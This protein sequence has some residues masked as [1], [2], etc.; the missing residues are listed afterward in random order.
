VFHVDTALSVYDPVHTPYN[1]DTAAALRER[2]QS[3]LNA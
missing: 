2:I 3:A 1:H